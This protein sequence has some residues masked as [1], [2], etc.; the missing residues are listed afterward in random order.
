MPPAN[1]TTFAIKVSAGDEHRRFLLDLAV[2]T[3]VS[4]SKTDRKE[5]HLLAAI[6]SAIDKD[7]RKAIG[8]HLLLK[9][10][11]DD[12]DWCSLT[13]DAEVLEALRLAVAAT[14][15]GGKSPSPPRLRLRLCKGNA[16]S[17]PVKSLAVRMLTFDEPV[18][19]EQQSPPPAA[20]ARATVAPCQRAAHAA[21][22][23]AAAAAPAEAAA[24][25]EAVDN[26]P[27]G[28]DF[29]IVRT[30]EPCSTEPSAGELTHNFRVR[31]TGTLPW[32]NVRAKY[33]GG[34][35]AAGAGA[36]YKG[37]NT[38]A[39]AQG[40]MPGDETDVRVTV[41]VPEEVGDYMAVFR[42][43]IGE[44]S[45]NRGRPFGPP[46]PLALSVK[47]KGG[48]VAWTVGKEDK[49]VYSRP[50]SRLTSPIVNQCSPRTVPTTA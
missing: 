30:D 10:C 8:T 6:V 26:E 20:V 44:S 33:I 12:G 38:I 31:N 11:D 7:M 32:R 43:T 1:T 35:G 17:T 2:P 13:T 34:R 40:V 49:R 9:F 39:V 19:A 48:G 21:L 22:V 42:L 45:C 46:L 27:A 16:D 14:G 36:L 18:V 37:F 29:E 25:A 23:A 15:C 28:L 4:A 24:S 5:T 47:N 41:H 3:T 50:P